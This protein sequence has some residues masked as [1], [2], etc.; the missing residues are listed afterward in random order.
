MLAPE[1]IQSRVQV[2]CAVTCDRILRLA[3]AVEP[4][5][6]TQAGRQERVH[7][8]QGQAPGEQAHCFLI[9]GEHHVVDAGLALHG[10]RLA[11]RDPRTDERLEFKRHMLGH[12][13]QPGAVLQPPHEPAGFLVRAPMPT[14]A[15]QQRQEAFVEARN[16]IGR[17]LLQRS[18]IH[19]DADH[20]HRCKEVGAAV[21]A[22]LKNPHRGA[23]RRGLRVHGVGRVHG[24]I[25]G[26]IQ[27]A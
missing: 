23:G 9:V 12:M 13:A 20:G 8:L 6:A 11:A 24:S 19:L 22:P 7:E 26:P 15:G 21:D 1:L 18:E 16:A 17:P 5:D 3:D 27:R 14:E 25:H 2:V 10:P 4:A